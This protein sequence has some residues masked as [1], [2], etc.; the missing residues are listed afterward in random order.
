MILI[1]FGSVILLAMIGFAWNYGSARRML[2]DR[3]RMHS[4]PTYH[5][6]HSLLVTLVTALPFVLVWIVLQGP[7]IDVLIRRAIA[8]A[9]ADTV[10]RAEMVQLLAEIKSLASG[11]VFVEPDAWKISITDYYL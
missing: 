1:A 9:L 6:T 3:G 11:Y 4:I 7:I 8:E 10:T 5:A 2:V